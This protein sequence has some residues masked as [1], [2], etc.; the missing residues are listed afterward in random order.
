VFFN[1]QASRYVFKI[2]S[3]PATSLVLDSNCTCKM[4][5]NARNH[6]YISKLKQMR[7][8]TVVDIMTEFRVKRSSHPITVFFSR[9]QDQA[10]RYT[11]VLQRWKAIIDGSKSF[12]SS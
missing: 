12:W 2:S 3:H 7:L 1:S 8:S 9:N 4:L 10:L 11:L 6:L 5:L